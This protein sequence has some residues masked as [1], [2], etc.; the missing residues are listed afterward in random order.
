M[1][2]LSNEKPDCLEGQTHIWVFPTGTGSTKI[3]GPKSKGSFYDASQVSI[4]YKRT[5]TCKVCDQ[6]HTFEKIKSPYKLPPSAGKKRR[7]KR[8]RKY[9]YG[10]N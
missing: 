8:R 10:K 7:R 9:T 2:K 5:A 3:F 4:N 6:K 1:V